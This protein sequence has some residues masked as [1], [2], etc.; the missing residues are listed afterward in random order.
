MKPRR[1]ASIQDVAVAAG[2]ST[3]TVSRVLNNPPLVAVETAARVQ[4]AISELG[5]T[6]NPFAQGL[7]TSRSRVLGI[8]LP[9]IHGEFYSELL[10][11]ADVE[12]STGG[13]HLLVSP[14]HRV[15]DGNGSGNLVF[16]LVDGLALMI[17][18]PNAALV[19]EAERSGLPLVVL[20]AQVEMPGVDRVLVDNVPGAT[21]AMEV[22]V[23]AVGAAHCAFVGGPEGNYDS[24]Q[25]AAVF[26]TAVGLSGGSGAAGHSA[27]T[28]RI[29]F[30]RYDVE[31]GRQWVRDRVHKHGPTSLRGWGILAGNDEIALGILQ[32]AFDAGLHVPGD[33]RVIG[34]DDTRMC[35]IVRPRL[36]SV[37]VP[38]AEVGAAAVRALM[39]RLEKPES[40]AT[41]VRL[42]TRLVERESSG[43]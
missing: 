29:A 41:C 3:A 31:W 23:R 32:A 28:D 14:V 38:M 15:R 21:Q 18:E 35:G 8:A 17:S 30:G 2:V 39:Q 13:Y 36:S 7:T 24:Q 11:G 27:H 40:P 4:R 6:P 33:L 22:L 12:A 34:F 19:A 1:N 10:R 43:G 16:G 42:P 20:D 25:R 37:S 9:D 5:Y 26:A